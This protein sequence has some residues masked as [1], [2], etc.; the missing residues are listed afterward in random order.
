MT[1]DELR[2]VILEGPLSAELRPLWD[3]LVVAGEKYGRPLEYIH[4]DRADVIAKALKAQGVTVTYDEI[5]RAKK[6]ELGW[7]CF[8]R[9]EV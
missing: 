9:R 5:R 8:Y 2:T 4:P 6:A 1:S 3:D 7:K